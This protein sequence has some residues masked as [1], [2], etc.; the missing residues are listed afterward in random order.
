MR[1]EKKRINMKIP[2]DLARWAKR[3]AKK[4]GTSMTQ[5]FVEYLARQRDASNGVVSSDPEEFKKELE[6]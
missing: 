1:M 6:Q 2:S 3:H 5:L 4:N